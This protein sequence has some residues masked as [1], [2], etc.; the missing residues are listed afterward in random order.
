[1]KTEPKFITVIRATGIQGGSVIAAALKSGNWKIR[2]VTRNI[3]SEASNAL[4]S[5]GVEMVTADWNDES[6]LVKAF[7]NGK[8][9][10]LF[11][12]SEDTP[13]TTVGDPKVNTG[14][15]ALA[16]FSQSQLTIGRIVL[17]QSET[18][19]TREII[20]LWSQMSGKPAEY[21]QVLLNY[22]DNLWPKWGREIGL[23]L[24]F[25][26]T[27]RENSWTADEPVLTKEDLSV[28]GHDKSLDLIVLENLT[29][30]LT[31]SVYWKP[32]ESRMLTVIG[33]LTS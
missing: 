3:N 25:W 20:N 23:V 14:I 15:Y 1:M 32:A 2:G 29:I 10:Q 12:V 16:I 22:Y 6:T 21:V 19:T 4:A 7:E 11:P 8:Y 13:I 9:V 27:A 24:Q 5:K 31:A 18:R 26:E 28:S 33:C 17:A 30:V